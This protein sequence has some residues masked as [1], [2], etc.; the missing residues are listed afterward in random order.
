MSLPDISHSSI[1]TP[2]EPHRRRCQTRASTPTTMLI[3]ITVAGSAGIF[4]RPRS[5]VLPPSAGCAEDVTTAHTIAN[6]RG[7]GT[8]STNVCA[9][10]TTEISSSSEPRPPSVSTSTYRRDAPQPTPVTSTDTS[11]A[12]A[13]KFPTEL[14]HALVLR[15]RTEPISPYHPEVW[16]RMLAESGLRSAYPK[17]VQ[18]LQHGFHANIPRIQSTYLPNNSPHLSEDP[19]FIAA[20]TKELE[21]ERYIGPMPIQEII[22]LLGPIQSSPCSVIPKPRN[23][24]KKRLIQ[25]FSH[26]RSPRTDSGISSINSAI[27]ISDFPST[28]G[29][30]WVMGLMVCSLPPDSEIA[31]RDVESAYRT[32]PLQ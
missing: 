7:R 11:A 6:A 26:P 32:I 19:H 22:E 12:S 5:R 14:S 29:T 25:N 24:A 3:T 9:F 15:R 20:V 4:G 18:G 23:P 17:L 8:A 21:K 28:W 13:A 31:I 1:S 16:E 27:E 2:L 30:P 10:G